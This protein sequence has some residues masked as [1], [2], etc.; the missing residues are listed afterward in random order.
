M[1]VKQFSIP[2][3]LTQAPLATSVGPAGEF[4]VTDDDG[5]GLFQVPTTLVSGGIPAFN[6][7]MLSL[8]FKPHTVTS[9]SG[10]IF[11][12]ANPDDTNNGFIHLSRNQ[13]AL[14]LTGDDP[15]DLEVFNLRS[16]VNSLTL[17]TWTHMVFAVNSTLSPESARVR[18][19]VNGVLDTPALAGCNA[20][21]SAGPIDDTYE[22]QF[23]VGN[24]LM[25]TF[26]NACVSQFWFY[27]G[28]YLDLTVEANRLKFINSDGTPRALGADGSGPTGSPPL[29]YLDNPADKWGINRGTG[30]NFRYVSAGGLDINSWGNCADSPSENPPTP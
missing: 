19:S 29:I 5:V 2:G 23:G 16:S 15:D 9:V 18:I 3:R 8:W 21:Y 22:I 1:A 27:P 30:S 13:R 12:I 26:F 17:D 20:G 7:F 4:A 10:A 24:E 28:A 11:R 14:Q 25:T 6:K